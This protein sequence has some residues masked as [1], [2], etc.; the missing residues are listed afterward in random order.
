MHCLEAHHDKDD[1]P[2][3]YAT[4]P[5]QCNGRGIGIAAR[6]FFDKEVEELS[7]L[8]RAFIAGMVKAPAAYNPFIGATE[9]RRERA[10][11]KARPGRGTCSTACG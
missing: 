7:T 11:G 8:E 4:V 2:E 1:I 9:E 5:C 6:Y 10:R 3:F